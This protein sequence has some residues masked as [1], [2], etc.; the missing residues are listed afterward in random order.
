MTI[1]D[2]LRQS[3]LQAAIQGKLTQQLPEDGT[4]ADVLASITAEKEQLIKDKKI[5]KEKPL[6]PIPV[7]EIPFDIPDNWVWVRLQTIAQSIVD[8]PHS[9]PIYFEN[10]TSYCAID[11]NCIDEFG[12]IIKFRYVNQKTYEKRT[13]RLIPLAN[14]IVYTREGSICRAAIL[15]DGKNICL[16][17]RVMLIRSSSGV[18]V[19]YL[20]TILMAPQTVVSLTKMQK[21]I[22]AKHINVKDVCA[23]TFPLP[24]LAEQHRIIARVDELMAKIDELET[25]EKELVAL[26]K[27]FPGDMK[28]SLLQAAMQGKLTRQLPEDGSAADLLASIK[29]EKEQ[30]N[31]EKKIKKEKPL[32]PIPADEIPFDIPDNWEWVRLGEIGSFTRGSGIKRTDITESGFPCIRY[33]ELYTTYKGK[34]SHT[35]SYTSQEVFQKAFKAQKND[36]LMALTGENNFD[37]AL[38]RVYSGDNIIA[39]GGDMTK[40]TP[41]KCNAQYIAF[42]INSAYG[43]DCKRKM[44][45]GNI[46]VHIS[47]DNLATIPIP[48]PPLA[49]QQRIVEKMDKLLP[50]CDALKEDGVA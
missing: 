38:A 33:G 4:A 24:P 15:P 46:I 40:F 29:V 43:I 20:K 39:Y 30:L 27:A 11:T 19:D 18:S 10:E 50:L 36:I 17:Q 2:D 14:D 28:A 48:L 45:K 12:N 22:G 25:V 31:K 44:A 41:L 16:G 26:K 37:I 49:E 3:V 7:D 6:A 5:K 13:E 34:F 9:T 42:V 35:V 21:G 32:A 47:N 8:C 1:C 23:L